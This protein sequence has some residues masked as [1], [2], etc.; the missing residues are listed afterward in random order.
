M[1]P[2]GKSKGWRQAEL[3]LC[4]NAHDVREILER[5]I[6]ATSYSDCINAASVVFHNVRAREASFDDRF[7]MT[8][9][10]TPEV[11]ESLQDG[12]V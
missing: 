6:S 11:L 1:K 2:C 3:N 9:D 8:G 10:V 5:P 4:P 12:I 7:L